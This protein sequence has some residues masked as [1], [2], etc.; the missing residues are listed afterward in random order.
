MPL[1]STRY[2]ILLSISETWY[3]NSFNAH[4]L[5]VAVV[6]MSEY[7]AACQN[8]M[9]TEIR[10]ANIHSQIRRPC[11]RRNVGGNLLYQI[12]LGEIT[13]SFLLPLSHLSVKGPGSIP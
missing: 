9:F 6:F 4:F 8:Q 1:E 12:I 2:R 13:M 11:C 7:Q 5:F 3:I 10:V